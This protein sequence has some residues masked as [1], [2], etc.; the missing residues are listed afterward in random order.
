MT[1]FNFRPEQCHKTRFGLIYERI[2]KRMTEVK[3]RIADE[4]LKELFPK[5]LKRRGAFKL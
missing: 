2:P 1:N 3:N 5:K 4:V